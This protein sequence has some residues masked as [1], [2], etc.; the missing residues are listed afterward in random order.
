MWY[1]I[2]TSPRV[3]IQPDRAYGNHCPLTF[4]T[5]DVA[6]LMDYLPLCLRNVIKN[7]SIQC[8]TQLPSI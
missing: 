2:S 8:R 1:L 4:H 3:S 7:C 5:A 6:N